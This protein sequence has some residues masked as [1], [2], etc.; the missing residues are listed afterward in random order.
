MEAKHDESDQEFWRRDEED[1][2]VTAR[3][4]HAALSRFAPANPSPPLPMPFF[5]TN[6]Q[7]P[8]PEPFPHSPTASVFSVPNTI[9][10]YSSS[11]VLVYSSD[12]R[13][14]LGLGLLPPSPPIDRERE[15]K[16][17]R[18]RAVC[19]QRERWSWLTWPATIRSRMARVQRRTDDQRRLCWICLPRMSIDT[20]IAYS[21][22]GLADIF[23]PGTLLSPIGSGV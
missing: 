6:I 14:M 19:V 7:H 3:S 23:C 9:H 11:T 12:P 15:G 13:P 21:T 2:T 1:R 16:R 4:R 8:S 5:P 18:K 10:T 22:F 20:T 17:S